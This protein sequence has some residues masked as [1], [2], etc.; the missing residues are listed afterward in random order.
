MAQLKSGRIGRPSRPITSGLASSW[1]RR[2]MPRCSF[3]WARARELISAILTSWGQTRLQIPQP[4][5]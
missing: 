4:E 5:Q 1:S 2:E 3:S